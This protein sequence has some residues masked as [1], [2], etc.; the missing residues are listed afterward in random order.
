[1]TLLST[2]RAAGDSG[3]ED[4]VG[5]PEQRRHRRRRQQRRTPTVIQME[6]VECGAACL[7][8][9][10]GYYGRVVPLEELRVMC[11]VSR[12]GASAKNIVDAARAYG[13]IGRGF[14]MDL[15]DLAALR[16]PAII[17]WAFQHFMV[18]EGMRERFGRRWVKVNDPAS[19]PRQMP[20]EEFD[21]G[22]TGIVLTFEP[23]PDFRV[24]GHRPALWRSLRERWGRSGVDVL[25]LTLLASVLLVVPGLVAPAY[26]RIFIDT[27]LPATGT[28]GLGG[29]LL[30]M[31]L[32]ALALF[33]LT[34]IQQ[35]SFI[36]LYTKMSVTATPGFF[37][38]LLTLPVEFFL[39]RQPAELAR[40]VRAN[41]LVADLLSRDIATTVV[42]LVLVLFYAGIMLSYDVLLCLIG[43]GMAVLNVGVLRWVSRLRTDAVARL[44]ADRGKLAATT[45]TTLRMIETVKAS[46]MESAT[47][48]RWAGFQAK[49]ANL[50]Q[51]L[52]RPTIM[53]TA[54]PP[55]LA[56]LDA[57]LILLIGGLKAS[58]GAIS[59]G[60]LV[61]FQAL[62]AGLSR[63]VSQLTNLGERLQDIS[64]DVD[65]IR[66][67][68]AQPADAVF[69]NDLPTGDC[70]L[71]GQIVVRDLTFGYGPLA[72]AVLHDLSFE[73]A[74]GR[75][76][77]LVGDS[78]S[79]K[80]TVGRIL[81]GT[82]RPRSGQILFDGRERDQHS[83]LQLATSI[84]FVE[85]D[86]FLFEGTIRDNLTLWDPGV[87]ADD[88]IAAL[89][90][91]EIYD[92]V[93][94]RPGGVDSRV[95]EGGSNF[96]GGQRQRLALARALVRGPTVLVMDEATSALDGETERRVMDNLLR[97]GNACLIIAHRLSTVRDCDEII[98]LRNGEAIER[99]THQELIALSGEYRRLV[100]SA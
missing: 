58:H 62:L 95:C 84:A 8:I 72:P 79:G 49:V 31:L 97:R 11:G 99:G 52:G 5:K 43:V 53:L 66:D 44:R 35:R 29:L 2:D 42:S 55:A 75:R 22:Y 76:I 93:A 40:R 14:R 56:T 32:T 73:L 78:G 83:R 10:L 51:T 61:A 94:R 45:I 77:A 82:Y 26:T 17:F 9:L 7:G 69:G 50:E 16:R 74:P 6:A 13:L 19:G 39:Q 1:M 57:G 64:A 12:D 70:L 46:G 80:S 34:E 30:A 86:V 21:G 54:V 87:P 65:R 28:D 59:V 88:V 91:A 98:V 23:G 36:T 89:R 81:S 100:S 90:D 63:P 37:R 48:S 41:N 20:Y 24:G 71:S 38:H 25:A 27:V 96:S 47:F 68:M 4:G 3:P 60:L 67:V 85:Q 18:V 92:V 33:V 15:D